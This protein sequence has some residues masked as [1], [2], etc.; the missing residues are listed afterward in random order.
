MTC[1]G[2][3]I[4]FG[5]EDDVPGLV[6]HS[7]CSNSTGGRHGPIFPRGRRRL[8]DQAKRWLN[9]QAAELMTVAQLNERDP[10]GDVRLW[11][12]TMAKMAGALTVCP[13]FR[14]SDFW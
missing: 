14:K 11:M 12:T 7:K 2:I 3:N 6:A 13:D 10:N 4:K 8:R 5:D 9:T 1:G